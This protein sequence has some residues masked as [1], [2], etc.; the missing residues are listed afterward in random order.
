MNLLTVQMNPVLYIAII[1]AVLTSHLNGFK[2]VDLCK[3]KKDRCRGAYDSNTHKYSETCQRQKC[4][5][6]FP[7]QCTFNYCSKTEADCDLKFKVIYHKSQFVD[8]K[9]TGIKECWMM[10]KDSINRQEICLNG[11]NC[12]FKSSIG[13]IDMRCQCPIKYSFEC[14]QDYCTIDSE[15]CD[16]LNTLKSETKFEFNQCMNSNKIFIQK[17]FLFHFKKIY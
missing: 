13:L 10:K 8:L 1:V 5:N 11:K 2:T 4:K 14:G 15:T 7:Y 6:D 9:I 17:K 16:A 3:L 12:Q